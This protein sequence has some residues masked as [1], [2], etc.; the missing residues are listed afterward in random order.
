MVLDREEKQTTTFQATK[1]FSEVFLTLTAPYHLF[2][3]VMHLHNYEVGVIL[4]HKMSDNI[5]AYVSRSLS[6]A[7][8]THTHRI[9]ILCQTLITGGDSKILMVHQ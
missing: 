9:I 2:Y 1:N 4:S 8:N 7:E 3:C 6:T 5:I